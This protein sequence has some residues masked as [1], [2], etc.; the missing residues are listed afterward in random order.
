MG[1]KDRKCQGCFSERAFVTNLNNHDLCPPMI[2]RRHAPVGPPLLCPWQ[3]QRVIEDVRITIDLSSV[4]DLTSDGEGCGDTSQGLGGPVGMNE[5]HNSSSAS[6]WTAL[7]SG[8]RARSCDQESRE[9]GAQTEGEMHLEREVSWKR[10]RKRSVAVA[11]VCDSARE[12]AG[13]GSCPTVAQRPAVG[14]ERGEVRDHREPEEELGKVCPVEECFLF[15]GSVLSTVNLA[16]PAE[17]CMDGM[18]MASASPRERGRSLQGEPAANQ[19]RKGKPAANQTREGKPAANQTREGNPAANQTREGKPAAN[20]TR[21]GKHQGSGGE[22]EG[23]REE[24]RQEQLVSELVSQRERD[25]GES[26]VVRRAL[27]SALPSALRWRGDVLSVG[28]SPVLGGGIGGIHHYNQ[29]SQQGPEHRVTRR[30][31]S[32]KAAGERDRDRDRSHATRAG[33]RAATPT[34]T[35]RSTE[36]Q[37]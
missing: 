26:K 10:S 33:T 14:W 24:M 11:G 3:K 4:V 29:Y 17:K 34:H 19:T 1:L 5:E 13:S 22:G 25:S 20:Q 21:E 12:R 2:L 37:G 31:M 36:A 28:L 27:P 15:D 18:E 6:G 35:A 9:A 30:S 8:P 7:G 16:T 23:E 32:M